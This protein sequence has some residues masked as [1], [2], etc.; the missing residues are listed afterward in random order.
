MLKKE[1]NEAYIAAAG[2]MRIFAPEEL[3]QGLE[4]V[5]FKNVAIAVVEA[6][7]WLCCTGEN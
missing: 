4:E 3:K 7:N 5:G 6:N 2:D 1:R